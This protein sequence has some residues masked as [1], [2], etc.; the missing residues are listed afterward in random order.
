MEQEPRPSAA[1][2]RNQNAVYAVPHDWASIASFLGPL[3]ERVDEHVAA[4]QVLVIA[5]DSDVAAA[6]TA[7]AATIAEG[8]AVGVL[9]ATSVARATRMLRAQPAHVVAGT[10]DVIVELLRAAALKLDAVRSIC[11]A[12]AD[13]LL[14]REG[15]TSADLETLMAELPKDASRTMVVAELTPAIEE[16]VERYARRARHI[17]TPVTEA[18]QPTG[19]DYVS[20]SANARLAA[21][22]RVL[23]DADP[24]SAVIFVREADNNAEVQDL[25]RALGYHG[26]DAPVRVG[27]VPPAGTD[28]VV[29]F[30][31][32]ASR[33]ELRD[34]VGG[35]ARTIALV[36]PRQL[37]SLRVLAAGGALHPIAL[38]DAAGRANERNVRT[39]TE[40]SAVLS[41][42]Q[43]W[44]EL[45]ALEPLLDDYDG[46]EI[47]AAALQLLERARAAKAAAAPAPSASVPSYDASAPRESRPREPRDSRSMVRL[48]VTVGTRDNAGPADLVGAIANTA[49]VSSSEIGKVDVRES[50]SIVE[51]SPRVADTVIEKL[52]GT[53][54]RGRRVIAKRDEPRPRDADGGGRSFDRG[55]PP[56]GGSRGGRPSFGGGGGRGGRPPS[57]GGGRGGKPAP[58]RPRERE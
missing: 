29:L 13:E 46:I 20:V 52:N 38:P 15:G 43:F 5:S 41:K 55:R 10:P 3:V 1:V 11:I 8:R 6:V 35:A 27:R 24:G 33:Q 45:L 18:D 58:R 32:P 36:Q 12:W 39:R 23:D 51:V 17:A 37:T 26:A 2:T 28:L 40:L 14:A 42:G 22:R 47:A 44:R 56:A 31:L 57:G 19:M 34:A 7:A 25:L 9:A 30:D 16:L 53:S 50:N 49:N 54:I 4:V 48:F 21:L